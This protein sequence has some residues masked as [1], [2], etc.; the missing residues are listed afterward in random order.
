MLPILGSS[1]NY[2]FLDI[3]KK[4]LRSS[5]TR[6]FHHHRVT[7]DCETLT[8][9]LVSTSSGGMD[10]SGENEIGVSQFN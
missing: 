7:F 1:L 4:T 2:N 5:V 8:Y 10:L 3:G 6:K 9:I